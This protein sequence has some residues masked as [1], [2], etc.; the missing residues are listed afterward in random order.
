M[1]AEAT[2]RLVLGRRGTPSPPSA[3]ESGVGAGRT[4]PVVTRLSECTGGL[5]LDWYMAILGLRRPG[6]LIPAG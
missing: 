2:P 6:S 5:L 1:A 3:N 4:R